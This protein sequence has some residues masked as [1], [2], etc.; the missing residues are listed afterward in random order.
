M[1]AMLAAAFVLGV[2]V[3]MPPGPVVISSGQRALSNGFWSAFAFNMGSLTS[4]TIYAALVYFGIS[5]LMTESN[6]FRLVLWLVGGAW[7]C[8][9]GIDAIRTRIDLG[10]LNEAAQRKPY[11]QNYRDGVFITL[12][13]PMTVV[14]WVALAGNFFAVWDTSWPPVESAGLLAVLAMVIGA[15]AWVLAIALALSVSRRFI[16]PRLLRLVSVG[17]G[18]FLIGFGLLAW[19]SAI[20]LLLR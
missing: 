14:A 13:N 20:E 8:W 16:S 9:L 17:S 18:L 5:A 19:S 6:V 12:L 3:A 11:W 7:L 15:V 2:V 4:D 1:F 10:S